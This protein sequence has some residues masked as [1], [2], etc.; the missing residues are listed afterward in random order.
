MTEDES[1]ETRSNGSPNGLERASSAQP[2]RGAAHACTG[3]QRYRLRLCRG[4]EWVFW[5]CGTDAA[6]V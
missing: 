2:Q 6:P 1:G 4:L 3:K 5:Q